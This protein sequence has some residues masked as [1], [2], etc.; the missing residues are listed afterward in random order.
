M[1]ISA[2]ATVVIFPTL[3]QQ[4]RTGAALHA[5][6]RV[7]AARAIAS[8][9]WPTSRHRRCAAGAPISPPVRLTSEGRAR[10]L[11]QAL[12][13]FVA[14]AC[15]RGT[16][17]FVPVQLARRIPRSGWRGAKA[18]ADN[19]PVR[20][21]PGAREEPAASRS[22]ETAAAE[23]ALLHGHCHQRRSGHERRA[24]ALSR[25]PKLAVSEIIS[26]AARH[27]RQLRARGRALRDVRSPWP[28]CASCR[29]ARK[30]DAEAA[31]RGR[32]HVVPAPDRDGSTDRG[33]R[34]GGAARHWRNYAESAP[35]QWRS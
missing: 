34:R 14:R 12:M 35:L 15:D 1:S 25:C 30:A 5:A 33:T 7:L 10:R 11:L 3:F 13:P 8:H 20:G 2:T 4:L 26:D 6:R 16:G 21:I 27:G 28:N 9:P 23:T 19:A 22:T 18:V 29:R 17:A 32:P 24:G 31:D